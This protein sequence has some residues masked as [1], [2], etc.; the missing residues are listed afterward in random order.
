MHP[1]S[2]SFPPLS[3]GL[4]LSLFLFT[5]HLNVIYNYLIFKIGRYMEPKDT[6]KPREIS[7]PIKNRMP[8]L[9]LPENIA[10][11]FSS[12]LEHFTSSLLLSIYYRRRI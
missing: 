5:L 10:T 1:S 6:L 9:E 11:Y 3:L 8:F 7:A 2:G 12:F 4:C